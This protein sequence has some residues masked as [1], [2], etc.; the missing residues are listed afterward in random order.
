M[1]ATASDDD[2][3]CSL[4]CRMMHRPLSMSGINPILATAIQDRVGGHEPTFVEDA[5]AIGK[6]M[7]FDDAPGA[8]GNAVIVAA[9]RDQAIM[10]DATLQFEK[11]IEGTGRQGLKFRLLGNEGIADD[12]LRGAVQANIGD[13]IEPT[14]QLIVQIVE[15]AEAAGKEEV[16]ADIA[17]W[18]LDLSLGFGAI[19]PAGLRLEAIVPA[20]ASSERL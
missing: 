6:L 18:S 9:D 3:L 7:D 15:I 17:E 20:S 4:P 5:D 2:V 14:A 10:A 13:R 1:V 11:G 19:G 12:A 8:V 16:L